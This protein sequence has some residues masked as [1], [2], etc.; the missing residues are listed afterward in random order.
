[1]RNREKIIIGMSGGV[2]S[3]LAAMLLKTDY[4]VVGVTLNFTDRARPEPEARAC[5]NAL[6]V[7]RAGRSAAEAGI[8]LLVVDCSARFRE[9]TL[10]QCRLL[11]ERGCTPN[12]CHICNAR[13]KFIELMHAAERIGAALIATGHYARIVRDDQGHPFLHRGVDRDKDQS[14]FLSGV[15]PEILA[16]T[17]FPLGSML[18]SET[19]TLADLYNLSSVRQKESQD[20]CFTGKTQHFSESLC[21]EDAGAATPGLF[22]D[23]HGNTL[24]A[25]NGIHRY[26][27]GQRKGLGF[28]AGKRVRITAIDPVTGAITVS[29]QREAACSLRCKALPFNWR[30]NPLRP[31]ESVEAQVRYRQSPAAAAVV[32]C[33]GDLLEIEFAT[34]V[35]G[36]T[37][38]Q[39]LVL[40]RDERVLGSGVI[41]R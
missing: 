34:P 37:P 4:E 21:G 28:A 40:Y 12:P 10:H 29:A 26:T 2:D 24:G 14:Y 17:L 13:V 25:H 30:L 15:P 6:A 7:E 1:M 19:R 8:E 20:L 27:V 33:E 16:R 38:G 35:F 31:G 9:E 36:V 32:K 23:E 11:F 3:S 41:A 18:K 5:G 22:I 39:I